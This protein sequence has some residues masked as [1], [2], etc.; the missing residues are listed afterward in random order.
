MGG[1]GHGGQRHGGGRG[2][3]RALCARAAVGADGCTYVRWCALVCR[4]KCA[5][6]CP[7]SLFP[8]RG[9]QLEEYLSG[10]G[11]EESGCLSANMLQKCFGE[12]CGLLE[13]IRWQL[14]VVS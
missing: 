7:H 3:W 4:L 10:G 13:A 12:R 1:V 11:R 2:E 5:R 9:G 8:A 6:V 14:E